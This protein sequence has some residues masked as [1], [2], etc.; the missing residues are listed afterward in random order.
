MSDDIK[1]RTTYSVT[2]FC[3]AEG[4]GK[5]TL[6]DLWRIGKGPVYY[7]I[8][9]SETGPRRITEEDRRQWHERCRATTG[10]SQFDD[11]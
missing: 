5:S 8:G 3:K 6:Y 11:E 7:R 1:N 2:E 4:I 10:S 9:A